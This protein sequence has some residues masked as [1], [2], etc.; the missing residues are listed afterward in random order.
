MR[1]AEVDSYLKQMPKFIIFAELPFG[2]RSVLPLPKATRVFDKIL[3]SL[4]SRSYYGRGIYT[5]R[6]WNNHK[7]KKYEAMNGANMAFM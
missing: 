1:V 4:E 6:F 3:V 2:P 5:W 7:T